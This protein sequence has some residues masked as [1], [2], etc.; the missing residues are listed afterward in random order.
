MA[1]MHSRARG[2]SGS[3]RP[4][5]TVPP[6]WVE[7]SPEEVEDLVIKLAKK[8]LSPSMIGIVLRDQYGI[9]S[10]KL[11]TKKSITKILEENNLG[12]KIPEDL[13]N[14]IK[15]AVNINKHMKAHKHDMT[16]KRGMQLTESK[17]RRLAKYYIREGKLPKNWK[18]DI[19][20]AK[21]LVR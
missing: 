10:V 13:M 20:K 2:K 4:F 12:L 16:A 15:K 21:L 14:L 19:E 3:T 5:R 7:Y 8:G 11:I 1:R 6:E 18:F 9:P 17:I